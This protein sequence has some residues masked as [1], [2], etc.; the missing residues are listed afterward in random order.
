MMRTII[1]YLCIC[2]AAMVRF[3]NLCYKNSYRATGGNKEAHLWMH[4]G[5]FMVLLAS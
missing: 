5:N 2:K 3:S 4:A 1:L